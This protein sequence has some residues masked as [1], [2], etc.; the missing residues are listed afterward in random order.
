MTQTTSQAW[1]FSDLANPTRFISLVDKIV[2]IAGALDD[3]GLPHAFGGALALEEVRRLAQLL[4]AAPLVGGR[5][6]LRYPAPAIDRIG[7]AVSTLVFEARD[8]GKKGRDKIYGH[9]LICGDCGR[10]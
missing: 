4:L 1:R 9:G 10:R 7:P 3:A 2:A 5:L 8:L 6:A